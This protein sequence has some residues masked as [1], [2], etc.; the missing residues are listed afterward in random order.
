MSYIYVHRAFHKASYFQTLMEPSLL[1]DINSL[2][3]N[4]TE[5]SDRMESRWHPAVS[6][7]ATA[8]RAFWFNLAAIGRLLN[9]CSK[10]IAEYFI[11]SIIE[12][13]KVTGSQKSD[14]VV[15]KF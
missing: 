4:F 7:A 6:L 1:L 14:V 11:I 12:F 2:W 13:N 9:S 15:P 5:A 8:R 3:F 10:I